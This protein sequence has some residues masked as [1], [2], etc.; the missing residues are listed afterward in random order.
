MSSDIVA[1]RIC[2][3]EYRLLHQHL[4]ATALAIDDDHIVAFLI[5][6]TRS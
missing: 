1:V 4:A 6:V 2:C 3:P 5:I